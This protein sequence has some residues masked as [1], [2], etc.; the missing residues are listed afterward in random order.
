MGFAWPSAVGVVADVDDADAVVGVEHRHAVVRPDPD[1]GFERFGVTGE[2]RVEHERWKREVVD[3]VD[4]G[5]DLDLGAVVAVDL[6]EHGHTA[7]VTLRPE[8]LDELEGLRD[9]ERGRAPFLDRVPDRVES[10]QRDAG[11]VE[12]VEDLDQVVPSGG[13]RHV[14]VDL[15]RRERG[16]QQA[17]NAE[18]S[19]T[20]K[21][22]P[23]RG[24][25]V[26]SSSASC[27]PPG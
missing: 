15:V 24:R 18:I 23:G 11:R 6:D 21:G 12:R 14:D 3:Q 16:P 7:G 22:S 8:P 26:A 5:G 20:V 19:V 27:A 13:V 4:L 17:G 1:P 2:D 10:H 9:H 25:Y